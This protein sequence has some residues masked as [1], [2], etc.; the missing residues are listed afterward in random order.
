MKHSKSPEETSV[1]NEKKKEKTEK[2]D[3]D[4]KEDEDKQADVS[5]SW[6]FFGVGV[7]LSNAKCIFTFGCINM[8]PDHKR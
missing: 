5:I 4:V 1:V 6:F 7:T 2:K 8:P 3:D